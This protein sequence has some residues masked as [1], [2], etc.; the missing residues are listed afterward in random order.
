MRNSQKKNLIDRFLLDKLLGIKQEADLIPLVPNSVPE[1]WRTWIAENLARG[2]EPE[3]LL[4]VLVA[5]GFSEKTAAA[6]LS[7]AENHPYVAAAAKI[8]DLLQR[9]EWLLG[10]CDSLH[11]LDAKYTEIERRPLP[12]FATFVEQYYSKNRPVIFTGAVDHWKALQRWTPHYLQEA[13]GNALVEIQYGRDSN[14]QYEQQSY[15]HRR[16][17]PMG[18]FV[19]M[20][21]KAESSNN[22]YMTAN[23]FGVT[24]KALSGLFDDV[25]NLGDGYLDMP[26]LLE[27][28][29]LWFGPKGTVTPLHHDLTNNLFVQIYGRKRFRFIPALQVPLMYNFHHVFSEVDLL[30]PDLER[31]PEFANA[32]V[33]DFVVEPGETL[34]I[35]IGWWHHVVALDVSISLSFTNFTAVP[36]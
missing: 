8:H 25:G 16:Q 7:E 32:R 4:S 9:R 12:D 26:R 10:M 33:I 13:Y 14:P 34:F 5:S 6:E 1:T 36:N 28:G 11:A 18:E 17:V 35:P 30:N 2:G 3:H 22:M 27:H 23:N 15:Q 29:Y 19:N 21:L 24:N 20:V 31:F